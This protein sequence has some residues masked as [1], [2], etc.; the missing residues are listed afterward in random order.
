MDSK[1][2]LVFSAV[3]RRRELLLATADEI[4][5]HPEHGGQEVRACRLLTELLKDNGFEVEVGIAGLP[6]SFRATWQQGQGGPSI[7]LLCEYDAIEGF[8]HGCAHHMQGPVCVGAALAIKEILPNNNYR[9]VVYGTPAEETFGGKIDML[10]EGYFRDIDVA[11]MMHGGPETCTDIKSLA[12]SEFVVSFQGKSAHAAIAPEQGRSAFDALL[13]SFNG[14]EFLR[15]HVKDDVRMHY[16]VE[17][18]P[19]PSNVVPG[20]AEGSFSLRSESREELD[21]VVERFRDVIRGAAL[22]AGVTAQVEERSAYDNKIPALRLNQCIMENAAACGA[23]G[24]AEARKKTGS[25]DFANILHRMPGSCIR[26]QFVPVGTSSHSQV[27]LDA[28]KTQAGHDAV[29]YGS[30]ILAG[31][32]Q[33]LICQ[34]ELMEEI[35]EE[36]S[37]RSGGKQVRE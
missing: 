18:L 19:G 16:T 35:R 15:E 24:L 26:V 4:F 8:G 31:T 25:T 34:P 22:M 9:L 3:D 14:M 7:G 5:D 33:D 27:W 32:A 28:G 13:L 10:R 17:R 1:K 23:P 37:R 36:F 20:T 11:L 29:I 12:M 6:T 2:Q 30:K 21:E